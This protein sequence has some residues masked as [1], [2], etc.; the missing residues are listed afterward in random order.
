MAASA[1]DTAAIQDAAGK[2]HVGRRTKQG[3]T[4]ETALKEQE[5]LDLAKKAITV[6]SNENECRKVSA[7]HEETIEVLKAA[8]KIRADAKQCQLEKGAAF[9]DSVEAAV[10]AKGSIDHDEALGAAKKKTPCT[11]TLRRSKGLADS[12]AAVCGPPWF[13]TLRTTPAVAT[14]T[15]TSTDS[16]QAIMQPDEAL[17]DAKQMKWDDRYRHR[18]SKWLL[19]KPPCYIQFAVAARARARA[20]VYVW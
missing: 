2:S 17:H 10:A 3:K 18:R 14:A 1:V 11:R 13:L 16:S 6:T 4:L 12:C 19:M 8:K 9:K 5:Q 15:A 20:F 7:T